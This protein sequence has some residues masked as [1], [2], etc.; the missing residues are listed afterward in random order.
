MKEVVIYVSDGYIVPGKL[1]E[2]SAQEWQTWLTCISEMHIAHESNTNQTA[3]EDLNALLKAKYTNIIDEQRGKIE[4]YNELISTMKIKIEAVKTTMKDEQNA[5]VQ[6]LTHES[7]EDKYRLIEKYNKQLEDAESSRRGQ[8]E[9]LEQSKRN[10]LM[11]IELSKRKQFEELEHTKNKQIEEVECTRR[12]QLEE[13]EC[14]RRKQ[15]E[16]LECIRRKQID[17]IEADKI[18]QRS[19]ITS[20][21]E[22]E[23]SE[24]DEKILSYVNQKNEL[25]EMLITQKEQL[26]KHYDSQLSK[27]TE[28]YHLLKHTSQEELYNAKV[29][30]REQFLS[31][32]EE[33]ENK[34]KQQI[35][36]EYEKKLQQETVLLQR[37]IAS[38]Q[39]QI[40]H[41]SESITQYKLQ[42]SSFDEINSTLK[43]IVKFYGKSTEEKGTAGEKFIYNILTTS[44]RY[45]DAIVEDTSGVAKQG[46]IY[47]KWKQMKCLIEVKNKITLRR[48]DI[49]KFERDIDTSISSSNNINCA[50]LISLQT[51]IFPGRQRN[52]IQFDYY[53]NILVSYLHLSSINDIHYAICCMDKLICSVTTNDEQTSKLIKHF[54]N[55]YSFIINT[56]STYEKQIMSKNK[57]IIQLTKL[58][59]ELDNT[60]KLITF[61]YINFVKGDGTN[62]DSDEDKEE[63]NNEEE[64]KQKKEENKSTPPQEKKVYKISLDS[65]KKYILQ[66]LHNHKLSFKSYKID[67]AFIASKLKISES[68][69]ARSI[70]FEKLLDDCRK[71]FLQ[72]S[73]TKEQAK[74]L[75]DLKTI[76]KKNKVKY[77]VKIQAINA[78]VFT[79]HISRK[80]GLISNTR[81]AYGYICKYC[82]EIYNEENTEEVDE[83]NT[84]EVDEEIDESVNEENTQL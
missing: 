46:D 7:N 28:A 82:E 10:Q 72:S 58:I 76:D 6:R 63:N 57:E 47:F 79:E 59:R 23:L 14:T 50:I 27:Q 84:E 81:D 8:I 5:I 83:E 77:P 18:N 31:Q 16:E 22:K 54:T 17:E 48:E 62:N 9:E 56:K 78:G 42:K 12:K 44:D 45:V 64:P 37:E 61:D 41:L 55:Y 4:E 66:L 73:I 33:K 20:R 75:I 2:I 65:I 53:N 21:F 69:L 24:R 32:Y 29:L 34:I 11:E 40:L 60:I 13:L 43:P 80:L 68:S 30:L 38:H 26:Q 35:I 25:A 3:Q 67:K 70:N 36:Q 1:C 51:D 52:L 71:E 74:I 19:S 39:S 15:I 49:E